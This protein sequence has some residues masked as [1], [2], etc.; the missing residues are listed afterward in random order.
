MA[1]S[2]LEAARQLDQALFNLREDYPY[3]E[4]AQRAFGRLILG[5]LGIRENKMIIQIP[6]NDRDFVKVEYTTK[7]G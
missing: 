1:T 6:S 7:E 5:K 2:D 3:K 4:Q